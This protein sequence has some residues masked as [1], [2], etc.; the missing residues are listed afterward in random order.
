MITCSNYDYIE[1][2]CLYKYPVTLIL[3]DSS[4]INGTARDIIVNSNRQECV[5]LKKDDQTK[6]VPL[7][8]IVRMEAG[9]ENP[10]FKQVKFDIK[11]K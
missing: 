1:I 10:H 3:K 4:K 8:Q 2:A 9:Q 6:T 5:V 7:E 11:K